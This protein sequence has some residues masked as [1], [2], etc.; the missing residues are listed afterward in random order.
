MDSQAMHF[1]YSGQQSGHSCCGLS[2]P[3][4]TLSS[5]SRR[6]I[7]SQKMIE[8]HTRTSPQI[9]DSTRLHEDESVLPALIPIIGQI[10]GVSG[11]NVV[12]NS[13]PSDPTIRGGNGHIIPLRFPPRS[14]S[15]FFFFIPPSSYFIDP[16]AFDRF[17]LGFFHLSTLGN[18]YHNT[19][20]I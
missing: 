4:R 3:F 8:R 15:Y 11:R 7:T 19:K 1:A 9:K 2:P 18:C 10:S 17:H 16:A 13:I 20:P 5:A 6:Q 12:I 14:S